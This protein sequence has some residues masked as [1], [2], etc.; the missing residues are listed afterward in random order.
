MKYPPPYWGLNPQITFCNHGSYGAYPLAV[1]EVLDKYTAEINQCPD[2]FYW[3]EYREKLQKVRQAIASFVT[4]NYE[5]IVVIPNATFAV[6]SIFRS[7]PFTSRQ[8]IIVI[9]HNYGACRNV[10]KYV[11]QQKN[12]NIVEVE[13]PFTGLSP[14]EIIT[15]IEAKCTPSTVLCFID[16]LASASSLLFPVKE[17]IASLKKRGI[18]TFVDGAHAPGQIELNLEEI[19]AAFYAG[20]LHKWAS[21][22]RGTAF[23]YVDQQY[24]H[25]IEPAIISWG[26][27]QSVQGKDTTLA[28]KFSI[29]GTRDLA[30]FMAIPAALSFINNAYTGGFPSF[31]ER[32]QTLALEALKICQSYFNLPQILPPWR[33]MFYSIELPFLVKPSLEKLIQ[34]EQENSLIPA[35]LVLSNILL[36]DYQIDAFLQVIHNKYI[37]RIS[38]YCYNCLEDYQKL[39]LACEDLITKKLT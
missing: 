13:I 7:F 28:E 3:V 19:G 17:I 27:S 22:P 14:A 4:A 1:K 32:N 5:N 26:S 10:I 31:L 39:C 23:C 2:A 11:A 24:H 29:L 6:N 18:L 25:L 16:H 34:K 35:H 21:S 30:P 8:E 36:R 9:N 12:L 33:A 20:N 38:S 15:K 37:L